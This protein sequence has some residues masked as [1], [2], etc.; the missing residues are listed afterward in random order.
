LR[1]ANETKTEREVN[2]KRRNVK[3]MKEN[4]RIR[5]GKGKGATGEKGKD[6]SLEFP[7][8]ITCVE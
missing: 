5:I 7:K 2:S 8:S 6:R 4:L 3:K 1:K